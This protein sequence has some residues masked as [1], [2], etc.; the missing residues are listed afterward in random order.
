MNERSRN[1]LRTARRVAMHPLSLIVIGGLLTGL[2]L[3]PY[4]VQPIRERFSPPRV[5]ITSPLH[6]EAVEWTPAGYLVTGTYSGLKQGR[7]LYVLVH[8]TPTAQWYVQRLPTLIDSGWQAVVYFGMEDV[9]TGDRYELSAIMTSKV[10][11]A[12]QVL[13]SFPPCEAK[14]VITVHR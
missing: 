6:E 4:V 8:P 12:G 1:A 14:D 3:Q 2:V 11:Q 9:G 5:E 7:N 13:E 10:L